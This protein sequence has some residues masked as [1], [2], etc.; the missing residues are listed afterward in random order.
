[1]GS[2]APW[3]RAHPRAGCAGAAGRPRAARAAR[4]ATAGAPRVRRAP[5]PTRS[6]AVHESRRVSL[7][8]TATFTRDQPSVR[9]RSRAAKA[10]RSATSSP[11]YR[12][13]S[14]SALAD[15]PLDHAPLHRAVAR[16]DLQDHLALDERHPRLGGDRLE[17]GEQRRARSGRDP[18][19]GGSARRPTPPCPPPTPRERRRPRARPGSRANS[20]SARRLEPVETLV[21]GRRAPEQLGDLLGA[22]AGDHGDDRVGTDEA[23]RGLTRPGAGAAS[24][25]RATIGAR[26]PSKSRRIP[27]R[28]GRARGARRSRQARCRVVLADNDDDLH[29]PDRRDRPQIGSS[30]FD[31]RAPGVVLLAS[32]S[33]L[34]SF[35][36]ASAPPT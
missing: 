30:S 6:A 35:C 8:R 15:D 20:S 32:A 7:P 9:S 13:A 22:A 28:G 31:L 26:E 11:A 16:H 36:A 21:R 19:P 34:D 24:S 10:S 5:R 1:M 23:R 17:R 2:A 3:L 27:A 29:I 4:R 25:G 33:A 12:T 14:S 18:E